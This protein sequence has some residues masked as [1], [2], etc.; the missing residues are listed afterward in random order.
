[1][2]SNEVEKILNIS[3]E[4]LR[5]YEN[6]GYIRPLRSDNGYRDY[7]QSDVDVL[8]LILR[9]RDLEVPLKEIK[10]V[11][12]NRIS[13]YELLVK[14]ERKVYEELAQKK[15]VLEKIQMNLHRRRMYFFKAEIP[16]EFTNE[17]VLLFN[18]ND[19]YIQRVSEYFKDTQKIEYPDILKIKLSLCTRFDISYDGDLKLF[20]GLKMKEYRFGHGTF[21]APY[22]C[23]VDLDICLKNQTLKFESLNLGDISSILEL[24]Q[25]KNIKIIDPIGLLTLFKKYDD[26]LTF[27]LMVE[28][29]IKKWEKQYHIDNPRIESFSKILKD[30]LG[31]ITMFSNVI[32]KDN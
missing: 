3:R 29:N 18:R 31:K 4:T 23:H 17:N 22:Y 1:M 16:M 21:M 32:V 10:Q 11:I 20:H 5:Y 9:L 14:K 25:L 6:Q 2:K 7:D 19:L 12:D 15:K 8:E 24:L 28:R 13:L 27:V 30:V 26:K